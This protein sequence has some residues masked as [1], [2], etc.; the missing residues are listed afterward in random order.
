MKKTLIKLISE[1]KKNVKFN[2]MVKAKNKERKTFE[3]E[4]D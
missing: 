1:Q 4:I 3:E 2:F